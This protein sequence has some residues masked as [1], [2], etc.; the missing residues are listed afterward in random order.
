M[1]KKVARRALALA[2][3]TALVLTPVAA[4]PAWSVAKRPSPVVIAHGLKNPRQLSFDGNRLYVAEAGT[5]GTGACTASSEGSEV[6]FGDTG[7]VTRIDSS[8]QK[9]VLGQLPSVAPSDGNSA[10]GPSDVSF[11]GD[12]YQ[13]LLGL[14]ANPAVRPTLDNSAHELASLV[15]GRLNHSRSTLADLGGYEAAH[16]PDGAGPD[17][18]P[19]GMTRA[20]GSVYVADAGGNSI[21]KVQNKKVTTVATLPTQLEEAPPSLGLPA[22]AKIP[23]QAVPTS[24]AVGPDGALYVSQLTG[25]PFQP[26]KASIYRIGKSGKPTVYARGLTNVT[27]LA[28]Y[29]GT[30]Y[31][32]Q[33]AD[34]GL[35]AVPE[36]TLPSGS[37]VKIVKG[38]PK[39]VV[40]DLVAPYG[41]ALRGGN[42][43]VTTCSVCATKGSVVRIK[44]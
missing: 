12:S 31:A 4:A 2:A 30:L 43:Y 6:C 27:D 34:G 35:L 44:L 7:G 15:A 3:T 25:F 14:G 29:R 40:D 32:V 5:G 38:A 13:V 16:D 21:L 19:A 37:L 17:S 9:R 22:G 39:T 42:A 11:T 36:D 10:V 8:G 23:A 28:W 24:V 26:G 1:A 20:G 33:I 18:N 41:V